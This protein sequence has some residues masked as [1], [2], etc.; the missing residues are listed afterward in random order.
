MTRGEIWIADFGVPFGSETGFI[1]PVIIVQ[2][3][4][5]NKSNINTTII[6]PLTSNLVYEEAAGNVFIDKKESRLSKDSVAVVS[7]LDVID[8]KRLIKKVHTLSTYTM[9]LLEEG[10][11]LILD[12]P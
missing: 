5:V 3:N 7:Q 6:V 10:V 1:R 12:L 8:K 11:S 9:N 2:N 4:A